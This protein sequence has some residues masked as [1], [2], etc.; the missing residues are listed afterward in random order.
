MEQK[1]GPHAQQHTV[2]RFLL[3]MALAPY[4]GVAQAQEA[5]TEAI[6]ARIEGVYVLEEWRRNGE[7]VH[8]PLVDGR[9]V[10]L[11]GRIMYIS[12]DRANETNVDPKC[13]NCRFT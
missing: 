12:H 7:V 5:T 6:K 10:L 13:I 4:M 9:T 3:A 8:P 2:Y 11:N 1:C